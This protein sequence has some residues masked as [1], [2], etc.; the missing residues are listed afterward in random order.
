MF[1]IILLTFFQDL[2]NMRIFRI[3][4]KQQTLKKKDLTEELL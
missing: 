1:I 2:N 4:I 3:R